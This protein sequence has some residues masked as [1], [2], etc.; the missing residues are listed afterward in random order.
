MNNKH[1][2]PPGQ[3]RVKGE[4]IQGISWGFDTTS[5]GSKER[6]IAVLEAN[7]LPRNPKRKDHGSY[8]TFHWENR[9]L[10]METTNNPVTGEY[11]EARR[12]DNEPGFAAYIGIQGSKD[13]VKTL[14]EDIKHFAEWIKDESP[15][16]REFV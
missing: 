3:V 12:R 9:K 5:F 6:F 11:F 15:C 2:C 4:C 14:V 7:N 8:K 1:G 10:S 13:E 16:E